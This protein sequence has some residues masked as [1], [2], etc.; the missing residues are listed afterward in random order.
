MIDPYSAYCNVYQLIIQTKIR[1]IS[2][3]FLPTN[4]LIFVHW[5]TA[6]GGII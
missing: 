6:P 3:I 4:L 1:Q 5:N 2:A